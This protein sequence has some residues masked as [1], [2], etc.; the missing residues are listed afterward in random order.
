MNYVNKF[1]KSH[2]Y[3]EKDDKIIELIMKEW[4]LQESMGCLPSKSLSRVEPDLLIPDIKLQ[5]LSLK[6][7][8]E[9]LQRLHENS[10]N[11][12]MRS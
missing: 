3:E 8:S 5:N 1:M 2:I 6:R 9:L 12:N 7:I 11:I 10:E 4:G